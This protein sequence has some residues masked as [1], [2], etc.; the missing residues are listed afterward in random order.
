MEAQVIDTWGWC[1]RCKSHAQA[2]YVCLYCGELA[3]ESPCLHSTG[4]HT[5]DE[6]GEALSGCCGAPVHDYDHDA[7]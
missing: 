2:F 7:I 5:P 3:D 4:V 1:A 6:D